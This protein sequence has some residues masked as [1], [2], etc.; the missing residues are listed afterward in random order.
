MMNISTITAPADL[1]L[2][3]LLRLAAVVIDAKHAEVQAGANVEFGGDDSALEHWRICFDV[4]R[5]AH[6]ALLDVINALN[7]H[8]CTRIYSGC[9]DGRHIVVQCSM[10]EVRYG[11]A[12]VSG[13]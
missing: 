8:G 3:Q 6:D 2:S 12:V 4:H 11:E 7:P 5:A 9:V 1:S 10:G 13:A